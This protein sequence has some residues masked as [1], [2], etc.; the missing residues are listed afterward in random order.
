[1]PKAGRRE[2]QRN[3]CC[4]SNLNPGVCN[5][6]PRR[7]T[8][9]RRERGSAGELHEGKSDK[10]N[11]LEIAIA[12]TPIGQRAVGLNREQ[13]QTAG[14]QNAPRRP[15]ATPAQSEDDGHCL[16]GLGARDG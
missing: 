2:R 9:P 4:T 11:A 16:N 13:H 7:I 14:E 10:G 12:E 3:K 1:M 5:L 8:G 15:P 6:M